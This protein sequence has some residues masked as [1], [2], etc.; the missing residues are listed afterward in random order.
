MRL[1]IAGPMT[2]Y[3]SF[4]IPEFD[5]MARTLRAAGHDAVSPAELDSPEIRAISLAS[6]DGA[7]ATLKSH[8]QTWGDFLA[9]DVKLIADDGIEG[10]VVLPGWNQSRG[11][12]LET[13]VARA[14]CGLPIYRY[15]AT[16]DELRRVRLLELAKAWVGKS[17]ISFHTPEQDGGFQP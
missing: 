4:N 10:V 7:L 2:G 5:A 6:P 16:Y 14:I 1:Y 12:R 13:F 9:R 11:A 8:G 3:R 15:D 17:D